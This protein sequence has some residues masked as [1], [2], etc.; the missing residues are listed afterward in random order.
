MPASRSSDD[1]RRTLGGNTNNSLFG[2]ILG[3][4]TN[5]GDDSSD[6]GSGEDL[7]DPDLIV[8][9][10]GLSSESSDELGEDDALSGLLLEDE[11]ERDGKSRATTTE[12]DEEEFVKRRL[13]DPFLPQMPNRRRAARNLR[14][15]LPDDLYSNSQFSTGVTTATKDDTQSVGVSQV[16]TRGAFNIYEETEPMENLEDSK[17]H[18]T[19]VWVMMPAPKVEIMKRFRKFLSTFTAPKKDGLHFTDLIK[20]M[21]RLNAN[22]IEID[23]NYLAHTEHVLAYFL[24]DAPREMINIFDEVLSAHVF[25]MYPNYA[26]I[27]PKIYSRI[28]NLP[29]IEEVRLLRQVH[30][31]QLVR[32]PGVVSSQSPLLPQLDMAKYNCVK[33]GFILGP[34]MIEPSTNAVSQKEVRPN[35]CPECHSSGPF[36]INSRETMYR[37]YQSI[38]LQESPGKVP[39]GR[40]PRT[41]VVILTGDLVD[42]CR[43]GDE[44]EVTGIFKNNFDV[45]LN[46]LNGFPVF[47]TI[48]EANHVLIKTN[49][50]IHQA[51]SREE[52]EE[53]QRISESPDII[54][55]IIASIAPSIYGHENIKNAIALSLFG[56]ESKNIKDKHII[57]G[58]INL[59]L[60]GDPGTAKS[61]FLRYISGI[62]PRSIMTTG[63]GASAVGLTASV[64]RTPGIGGKKEFSLEAGALV[65]ADKGVCLIDEFDKMGDQDRTSIHEAMEQQTISIS[66]AGIVATLRARCSVIAACNPIGGKYNCSLTF[67]DNVDLT[68]PILSRFDV[69]CTVL[70]EYDPIE[71][72][73][74][75]SFVCQNHIKTHPSTIDQNEQDENTRPKKPSPDS[76]KTKP[77]DLEFL[78]KYIAYAKDKCHPKLSQ[79][80]RDKIS[81]MYAVLRKESQITNSIP[82]TVRHVES[83]IR[84][85][86]AYAKMHLRDYVNDDDINRAMKTTVLSFIQS[87]KYSVM[88]SMKNMLKNY[89][90]YGTDDMQLMIHTL[91]RMI[92]EKIDYEENINNEKNVEKISITSAELKE[93]LKS[94]SSSK[95]T[96]FLQSDLLR[97]NGF[98]FDKEQDLIEFSV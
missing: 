86:E 24:P 20:Q 7:Y 70:D 71:D 83:V 53:M 58:D 63:Q 76:L 94:T 96:G 37:N 32:V 85:A 62:A 68:E 29:L 93:V 34:F 15:N 92:R 60:C 97:M 30:L 46:S 16:P 22:S 48:I 78:Q 95:V 75:A 47:A 61:Q 1:E 39:A 89:L 54:E 73:R 56:G 87:Q 72:E 23:Y 14:K 17:G 67:K 18:A 43:P 2:D 12:F 74:L 36:V 35:S 8:Q 9:D 52:I 27:Q 42:M 88:K 28:S 80:N 31:N 59:L 19:K 26:R 25:G 84:L 91:K 41:K 4:D 6:E 10:Q 55:R 50:I 77:F 51:S 13:N 3:L 5:R 33:C 98:K 45:S 49:K 90:N 57:R 11:E 38:K 82:I 66:K 65:L 21:I 69:L 64:V 81:K 40:L 79:S 44:I